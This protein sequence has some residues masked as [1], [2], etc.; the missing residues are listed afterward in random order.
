M[1]RIRNK[2]N[3]QDSNSANLGFEEK[4][5]KVADKLRGQ[6]DAAE[7]KHIVLGLIFL[8]YISDS[9]EEHYHQLELWTE[10]SSNN[11]YVGQ[12]RGYHQVLEDQQQ[13]SAKHLFLVPQKARWSYI[14]VNSR[15]S[16]IGKIIDSAMHLIEQENPSLKS[17][18]PKN[19]SRSSLD[20]RRLG[21]LVELIGTIGLGDTES[22]ARDIL[23][24]VYEYFL[25]RFAGL[26]AKGGEFYTPQ[27]VVN[28]LVEMIQ[29]YKGS[30]Y[31][32]CCGSGGMFVQSEK[33]VEAHGGKSEDLLIYG[34][35]SNPTTW[36]LCKMN[37]ALRK[38][39]GNI[40]FHHADTFHNDLHPNLKADYIL[41]NPPFNMSDWGGEHLRQ[42]RRWQYG[43]PPI[44]NANFA[45][46]EHIVSHLASD[47]VAGFVLSNG[48]LNHSQGDG[49]IRE[50][51]IEA[52]LI[53]CIVALPVQLFYTTQIAAC[54]WIIARNKQN[55]KYRDRRGKTLFIYAHSFGEMVDRTHRILTD[56]EISRIAR[57]YQDW[58]SQE[59]FLDYR[60]IPGF[61]K[62]A[63]LEEIRSHKMSL[64]PGR[65]VGF[66]E[67]LTKHWDIQ[68]L[69]T[70]LADVEARL[71]EITKASNSAVKVLKELLHG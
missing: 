44:N 32:P 58:R 28:L 20:Q 69:Q 70:E 29:P 14:K 16:D 3:Q 48:A 57:T 60:D 46:V 54:L 24:R 5:W 55:A 53:D 23:G 13:N 15:S 25:G 1:V 4:L 68:R 19:F 12:E 10:T 35:E 21:E 30:V 64:V 6:M 56:A 61:C 34:Q 17:I 43:T 47:G 40:G 51:L 62:S 49:V 50:A 65:Y 33:F 39:E 37:L 45:W 22:R 7:Y 9:C 18:L 59:N 66:D 41:A 71:N 11:Y 26:E 36:R 8:K 38:I 63:T 2:I 42:D 67:E 52:D 31:D 27:S